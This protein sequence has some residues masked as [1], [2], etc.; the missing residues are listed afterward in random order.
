MESGGKEGSTKKEAQSG[1]K[2]E[3]I[4]QERYWK[5]NFGNWALSFDA[6][7]EKGARHEAGT[8]ITI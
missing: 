2:A 8:K 3:Q 4:S 5:T 1:G 6:L 7:A